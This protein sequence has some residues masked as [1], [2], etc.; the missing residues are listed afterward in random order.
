[1]FIRNVSLCNYDIIIL[2]E[3]WLSTNVVDAELGLCPLYNI[4]RCDRCST[5]GVSTR[6]GG[7]L[8]AV[9]NR[10]SCH[11]L[12]ICDN[13]V[14]QLFIRIS[15]K[16]FSLIIGAVYIPPASDINVYDIHFNTIDVLLKE[17][18][19][20]KLLICGDYNLS[21]IKWQSVN[22]SVV[23]VSA[24]VGSLESNVLARLS[25]Q[26]LIQFNLIYNRSGSLLDLVLSNMFNINIANE[27]ST[28]L[29]LD[30][31]YHPA[32]TIELPILSFKYLDYSEQMYDFINCDYNRI[33]SNLALLDWNGIFNGLDINDAV[34]AFYENIYKII[35]TCCQIKT[36]YLPKHP[37]WFSHSL[38][39]L[40]FDKK[41]AHKIYKQSPTSHNY[42]N[43]SNLRA[44][45]KA[46]NKIDYNMYI[47]KLKTPLLIILNFSGNM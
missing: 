31:I 34:N 44:R 1:L 2:T 45:C 11:R 25:F 33:R 32:L 19:N 15:D 38:K 17:N 47:R 23:P 46:K 5:R 43:F 9:N 41:I 21:N 40:I 7:V 28:L 4:F 29:P 30:S 42:N 24:S 37:R 13:S 35:N 22:G 12:S 6:G 27:N 18:C 8:I 3:T 26:N 39:K 16:C 10:F 36:L 20:S 14:E